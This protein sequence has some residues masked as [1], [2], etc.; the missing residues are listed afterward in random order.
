MLADVTR[1]LPVLRKDLTRG[2]SA[3]TAGGLLAGERLLLEAHNLGLS[4]TFRNL[5][6]RDDRR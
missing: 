2:A 1:L 4:S 6:G 3:G 5:I